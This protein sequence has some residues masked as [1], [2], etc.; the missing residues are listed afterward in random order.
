MKDGNVYEY[1]FA[2][3]LD[4]D[5][6]NVKLQS[7]KDRWE[8]LCPGFF[9]WFKKTKVSQFLKIVTQTAR[10]GYDS[11]ALYYQNDIESIHAVEE[12]KKCFKKENI[13]TALSNIQS[14]VKREEED[15]IHGLY[16]TG[17]YVLAPEFKSFRVLG[18]IWHSWS[19][20]R[21]KNHIEAFRNHKPTIMDTFTMLSNLGNHEFA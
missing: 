10:T 17:N 13:A 9:D 7:L 11:E 12:R 2:E 15:E 16:G 20:E 5:D 18:H 3:A 8:S 21:K 14:I 6:F 1:G 19:E 4:K